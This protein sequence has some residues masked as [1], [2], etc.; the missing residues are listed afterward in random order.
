MSIPYD[1]RM[2]LLLSLSRE[3]TGAFD[4]SKIMRFIKASATTFIPHIVW[5]NIFEIEEEEIRPVEILEKE[6]IYKNEKF[7]SEIKK[8]RDY[9]YIEDLREKKYEYFPFSE[10]AKSA[11][12][13]PIKRQDK[14]EGF[15]GIESE[16][17]KAFKLEDIIFLRILSDF[18]GV[19]I[20][21]IKLL[22]ENERRKSD[23][24]SAYEISLQIN[25]PFKKEEIVKLFLKL[26][27][28]KLEGIYT[29]FFERKG[30]ILYLLDYYTFIEKVVPVN[31]Q[32]LIGEGLVG[33]CALKK[34]TIYVNDV[35]LSKEYIKGIEDIKSEMVVP[36]FWEQNLIGVI[37][38]GRKKE[39]T[40][41]EVFMAN[42]LANTFSLS[43]QNAK[44][45]E[46]LTRYINEMEEVV[47]E[48]TRELI[49]SEKFALI[50]Q[51]SSVIIHEIKNLLSGI[52]AMTEFILLKTSDEKICQTAKIIRE[53]IERALKNL[54]NILEY[55]RPLKLD[56]RK[57]KIEEVIEKAI[58]LSRGFFENKEIEVK[59][60]FEKDL[61]EILLDED[62]VKEVFINLISNAAHAIEN[63]G[64]IK[65]KGYRENN[66]VIVEV[67]DNGIG[68]KKEDIDKIFEPF[69][70]TK[71]KGTGIGLAIV[72]KILDYHLWEISVQ[73]EVGKGS[74]FK[75][76]IPLKF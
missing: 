24:E 68:I 70:T 38:I 3:I 5:M 56:L 72:K 45:Y 21:N 74:I 60:D 20:S 48:K 35:S 73:S 11:L 75:I 13:I 33:T 26:L 42:L 10:K 47:K 37:D 54:S 69:F 40:R 59:V 49:K 22:K 46:E 67:E 71:P 6:K 34:E 65:I 12:W 7:F 23:F 43:Y 64:F 53:E 50:G 25:R 28:E 57:K 2:Q 63:K 55:V 14:L 44:Y 41:S 1:F 16:I 8:K 15:F 19:S 52:S 66:F 62:R 39:F 31:T 51:M 17:V 9:I 76:K 4:L 29:A 36:I 18:L 58:V 32:F 61:P 27:C 30:D